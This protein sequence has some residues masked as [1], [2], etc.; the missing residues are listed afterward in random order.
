MFAERLDE[1]MKV[2]GVS[3]T[4]LGRALAISGSHIG[5]LRSGARALPREHGFVTPMCDYLAQ[6]I[7][8]DHQLIA[9]REL[10]GM[11]GASAASAQSMA[12][13]L[14]SWLLE[15]IAGDAAVRRF[16]SGFSRCASGSPAA[17]SPELAQGAA[18]E[19]RAMYYHGSPGK[20]RAV[21]RFFRAIL[22][23]REPQTLSLFSDESFSWLYD[24]AAFAKQWLALFVEVL[25]R[26]NRVRVIHTVSRDMNEMM[27]GLTKWI[28]IYMTGAIEPYYYPRLRDGVFQRTLFIAPKTAA[29]SASS[30]QQ[31]AEGSLSFYVSDKAAVSALA[32]EYEQFFALCRPLMKIFSPQTAPALLREMENAGGAEGECVLSCA[33]P[34]LFSMPEGLAREI[35]AG[36]RSPAFYELW[37]SSL[38]AFRRGIKKRRVTEFVLSREA[39]LLRPAAL[40]LPLADMVLP[41]GFLYTQEQYLAQLARLTELAGQYDNFTVIEKDE[42]PAD[43][44]VYHKEDTLAVVAKTASPSMAFVFSEQNMVAALGDY[45]K[46]DARR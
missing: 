11:D 9:L 20:R 6:H 31:C 44:F 43:V 28:P 46:K 10:T 30:A 14:E 39:A 26:G 4:M 42:L 5:R 25:T 33:M 23:E 35:A 13:F 29:I 40:E 18:H 38:T 3:N 16:V 1:V 41:E 7:T 8:K 17:H 22:Q 34:L 45:L 12:R 36:Y 32:A 27:E 15:Q 37:K 21:V 2:S 24:D 19:D